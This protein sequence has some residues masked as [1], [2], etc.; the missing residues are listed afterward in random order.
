MLRAAQLLARGRLARPCNITRGWSSERN[1]V[2][3]LFLAWAVGLFLYLV[4]PFGNSPYPD[5]TFHRLTGYRCPGCGGTRALHSLLHGEIGAAWS[6]NQLIT[7]LIA[8]CVIFATMVIMRTPACRRP[9]DALPTR[10]LTLVALIV[11]LAFGIGRNA[12][13]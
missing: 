7:I 3:V 5:C 6:Y 10:S 9:V 13:W 12:R 11:T 8:G 1:A 4:P 2:L